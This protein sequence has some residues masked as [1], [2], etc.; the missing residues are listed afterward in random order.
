MSP[1]IAELI[2]DEAL[3]LPAGPTD[4]D[5][6]A[7]NS[8]MA[9]D[10]AAVL[11]HIVDFP[12]DNELQIDLDSEAD[13]ERFYR[14]FEILSREFGVPTAVWNTSK[15]GEGHHVRITMPF[16]LTPWQRIALQAALGSDPVRELLSAVRLHAG[17]PHPTLFFELPETMPLIRRAKLNTATVESEHIT[18]LA[19]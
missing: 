9:I 16:D 5:Y 10:N 15:S 7:T 17:D 8:Q 14:S 13:K 4:P 19:A 11:G 6:L 1:K 12:A 2:S 3:F 18:D